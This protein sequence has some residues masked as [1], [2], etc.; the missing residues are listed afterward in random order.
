MDEVF[1]IER[2][3][4]GGPVA[5]HPL[6]SELASCPRLLRRG[7]GGLAPSGAL[8]GVT[9][10]PVSREERAVLQALQGR[11]EQGLPRVRLPSVRRQAG[12]RQA[13]AV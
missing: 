13:A 9:L 4:E 3:G 1:K 5:E 6:R 2:P 10:A 11:P 7:V 8:R 12:P